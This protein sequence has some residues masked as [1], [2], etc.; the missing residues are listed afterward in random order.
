MHIIGLLLCIE[1]VAMVIPL[2]VDLF[3]QNSDWNIF[4]LSALITFFIG[5]VLYY[6]FK[7]EKMIIKVREAFVLTILSWITIAV[8]ASIP[9]VFSSA[10]LNYTDSFFESIS[11]ITTTGAT[12]I[13][14]LDELHHGILLWRS[15]L[16]WFGGIGII[17]FAMAILP[18]LQIGGMQLLHME[19]DDPYEKTLP[20]INQFILEIFVLYSFLTILCALLYYLFGMMPF[21][22]ISHAMTTISTGGFSTHNSSFVFFNSFKIE[23]I[24]VMFMIIGS[25]PFVVYL[26]FI[27]GDKKSIFRDDQ[28]KLFFLILI[29]LVMITSLWLFKNL[30]KYDFTESVRLAIFNITSILTGTGYSSSNY[31]IWGSF[32]LVI[33]IIIMFIGGCAGSTTGG[34]KIFRL[35]LLFRGAITQIKRLT[36]PHGVFITS[37]NEKSV[38]DETF[39]SIMGFFFMYILIFILASTALSLYNLDFLTSF[40]AAAS[41]ISNVGPGL[42]NVIGPNSNYNSIPNGAKWILS[43]T[44]LIGRLELFTFLVILSISFWKK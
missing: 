35:Q 14:N 5:L 25:L 22:A 1:A 34:I 24:A 9:F 13:N 11:G 4:L 43:F 15:L 31:N 2:F 28:I 27:H 42:G 12:V 44:M 26:K 18:T 39:N 10:N 16:Q 32:G 3:Y 37:F 20:K 38:T 33:M 6:S 30:Q 7:K 8:F 23:V 17:V 40:S 19:Q 41:A 36:Q 21:D 29:V